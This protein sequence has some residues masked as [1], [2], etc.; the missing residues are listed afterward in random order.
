MGLSENKMFAGYPDVFLLCHINFALK[1]FIFIMKIFLVE[2]AKKK[3]TL[4]T[5]E[6]TDSG[7][8]VLNTAKIYARNQSVHLLT[9]YWV[10]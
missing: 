2:M 1:D 10:S 8:V 4:T 9:K 5:V 7:T 3:K 6:T